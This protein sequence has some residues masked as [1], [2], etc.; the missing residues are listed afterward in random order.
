MT[1]NTSKTRARMRLHPYCFW[2]EC[3]VYLY[4]DGKK[5]P[6]QATTDHIYQ[7]VWYPDGRPS[8]ASV[9]SCHKCNQ[10][11]NRTAWAIAKELRK[12]LDVNLGRKITYPCPECG[13]ASKRP[14]G[15]CSGWCWREN[16]VRLT[17]SSSDS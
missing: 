6:D 13:L 16:Q 15:F 11:R 12:I 4:G 17:S 5:H 3:R 7:K 14:G 2:C 9:L 8:G 1:G 10:K